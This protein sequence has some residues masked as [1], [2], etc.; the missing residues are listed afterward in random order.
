MARKLI[1]SL[2]SNLEQI[3]S[4][5]ASQFQAQGQ[6]IDCHSEHTMRAAIRS[7][8]ARENSPENHVVLAAEMCQR[9]S[10]AGLTP[11]RWT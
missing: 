9:N 7:S 3:Q 10:L 8:P 6:G 1:E 11:A 5:Q 2:V 4:G